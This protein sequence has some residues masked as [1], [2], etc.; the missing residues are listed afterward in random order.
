[1]TAFL[2]LVLFFSAYSILG[3][4]CESVWCS[5]GTKKLV[6]R[7]FLNGPYC[8]VYGF[9]ALL[10]LLVCEPVQPYPPLVF[11]LAMLAASVLEYFTGWLLE[12]LFHTKWW[13]YSHR[14]FQI[15]GRV[16]LRNSILFGL[17]GL[18]LT[19]GIN[20]L[21][22]RGIDSLTARTQMIAAIGMLLVF[23]VDLTHTVFTL[24]GLRGRLKALHN[25][26]QELAQL[27][28]EH[29]WLDLRDIH[30]SV[31]RLR[32]LCEES[33]DDPQAQ[34]LLEKIDAHLKRTSGRRLLRAFP[35]LAD[36]E[37]GPELKALKEKWDQEIKVR[38]EKRKKK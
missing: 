31:L 13:D 5:I 18:A 8:P 32:T 30:G 33:P 16:C 20:P 17:L 9:G 15:K 27:N 29:E 1:M 28:S 14:K 2:R 37:F 6:N 36:K 25:A 19:Y 7:G 38:K 34:A 12:T 10:I 4:I 22:E 26:L 24:I 35:N 21:V 11:L 23:A 3:W